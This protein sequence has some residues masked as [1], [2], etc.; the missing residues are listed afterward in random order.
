M[1]LQEYQKDPCIYAVQEK[2]LL[3]VNTVDTMTTIIMDVT[4][5]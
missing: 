4:S 3:V 5:C 2:T 1:L